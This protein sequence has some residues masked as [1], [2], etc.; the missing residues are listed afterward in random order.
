M[1]GRAGF[2]QHPPC[3]RRG[4]SLA[5]PSGSSGTARQLPGTG[6]GIWSCVS[7]P[8]LLGAGLGPGAGTPRRSSGLGQG[9][10]LFTGRTESGTGLCRCFLGAQGG[11]LLWGTR[12][13]H[14]SPC[15]T[16]VPHSPLSHGGLVEGLRP[17]RPGPD[18]DGVDGQIPQPRGQPG[19]EQRGRSR[20]L[21][22]GIQAPCLPPASHRPH[23][24]PLPFREKLGIRV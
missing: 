22:T 7:W 5:I 1:K 19:S 3:E 15:A 16:P 9:A 24:C 13:S 11:G 20:G 23:T 10:L 21:S 8:E 18:A 2:A 6:A 17:A 14:V 12:L 4:T